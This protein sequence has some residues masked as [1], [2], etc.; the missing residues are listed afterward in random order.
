VERFY[1]YDQY[2]KMKEYDPHANL[3]APGIE[4]NPETY[5]CVFCGSTDRFLIRANQRGVVTFGNGGMMLD[6][7]SFVDLF[8]P[9]KINVKDL[10]AEIYE[11]GGNPVVECARCGG[12]GVELKLVREDCSQRGCLGCLLCGNVTPYEQ[13]LAEIENCYDCMGGDKKCASNCARRFMRLFHG[14]DKRYFKKTE[15]DHGRSEF[16]IPGRA[17]GAESLLAVLP[18]MR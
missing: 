9:S 3:R 6:G 10:M 11:N 4:K 7:N 5:V 17:G 15:A 16:N 8:C 18:E 14:I 1:S 13:V 12:P 2:F